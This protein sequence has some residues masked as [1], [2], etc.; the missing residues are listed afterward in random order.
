MLK[1]ISCDKFLVDGTIREPIKFHAGLNT[2]VGDSNSSNSIGKSTLMMIID[3]CFGGLD[4]CIKEKNI[5]EHIGHHEIKFEFEFNNQSKFFIRSTKESNFVYE[6]NSQYEKCFK[7]T[8]EQFKKDLANDYKLSSSGLSLREYISPYFRIYNRQTHNENR[9]LN[10]T[11]READSS[12]ITCLLKMYNQYND[13]DTKLKKYE[14]ANDCKREYDNLA[15][16]NI[17]PIA[18][19]ENEVKQFKEDINSLTYELEE[20]NYENHTGTTDANLARNQLKRFYLD[21]RKKLNWQKNE[22]IYRKN[23][24]NIMEG[25][26]KKSYSRQ[27][28][29]LLEFFPNV[30][31]KKI[32][33]VET[34]HK[35]IAKIMKKESENANENIDNLIS[36]LDTKIKSIDEEINKMKNVPN[37]SEEI[38]NKQM[39]L[40]KQI[41]FKKEAINNFENRKKFHIEYELARKELDDLVNKR[42]QYVEDRINSE[43]ESI[44][45]ELRQKEDKK[46]APTFYINN[47]NSY[48][49]FTQKDNGTGTRYKAVCLLDLTLLRQTKLPIFIHDSIMYTNI[50]KD[51]AKDLFKLYA[52]ETNKQ[53]IIGIAD[54]SEYDDSL[55]DGTIYN[56]VKEHKVIQL[57]KYGKALFGEQ[58][59]INTDGQKG[60][61]R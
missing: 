19:S 44:N 41:D 42:T 18:V 50:E 48:S 43:L 32:E 20:L 55:E 56:I 38:L 12:G 35:D 31:L 13:I 24:I 15:K 54:P 2:I 57:S 16:F 51:T 39:Y 53:I 45:D 7:L 6:C 36:L 37:V 14:T 26:N 47:L 49:F 21:E 27:Y 23:D 3:F 46:Y 29:E 8:L 4:Y 5:I 9:P 11:I 10:A 1:E 17:A 61:R 22:L 34:F 52:Q 25:Y 28:N 30:N 59:N 60:K 58:I 33:D 40:L